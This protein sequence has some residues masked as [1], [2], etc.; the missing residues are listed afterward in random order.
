M[1]GYGHWDLIE[2]SNSVHFLKYSSCASM[3]S[4]RSINLLAWISYN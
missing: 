1:R 3:N 2:V 4:V